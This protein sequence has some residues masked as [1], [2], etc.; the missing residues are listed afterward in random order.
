LSAIPQDRAQQAKV[1]ARAP[2]RAPVTARDLLTPLFFFKTRAIIA[3]IL[4][5]LAALAVAAT[6][7]HVYTADTRLLIL[8]GDDYT[9]RNPLSA[10]IPGLSFDRAQIVKAET[11]IIQS[12]GLIS[13]TVQAVGLNRLFPKAKGPGA[14]NAA[15]DKVAASITVENIPQ[16]NVVAITMKGR[17]PVVVSDTLNKLVELY[18]ARRRGIFDQNNTSSVDA[19]GKALQAQ[20]AQIEGQIMDFTAKN[21]VTDVPTELGVIAAQMNGLRQQIA[22]VD[23]QLADRNGRSA[24]LRSAQASNPPKMEV[25]TDYSRSLEMDGLEQSLVSLQNQRRDAAQEYVDNSPVVRDLDERIAGVKAQLARAPKQQVNATRQGVN[26]VRQ[27]IDQ[28]IMA[29]QADAA[30]LMAARSVAMEQL[31]QV[32][33]LETRLLSLA[34]DYR[35]LTRKRDLLEAAITDLAKRG[36]E[37]RLAN[38]VSRSQANIRVLQTAHPPTTSHTGRPVILAAGVV[39]GIVAA[40]GVVLVS[41]ALFQGMLTPSAAMQKLATPVAATINNEP[42]LKPEANTM[43]TPEPMFMHS[44][45]AR[46]LSHVVHSLSR[47]RCVVQVMGTDDNVGV[48]ALIADFA[49]LAARDRQKVLLLDLEPSPGRSALDALAARGAL[50]E[51]LHDN[52]S[53]VRVTGT[54]LFVT[55]NGARGDSTMTEREWATLLDAIAKDFD[56]LLIDAPP[57]SRSLLSLFAAPSVDATLLVIEAEK[58]RAPVALNTIERIGGV[59]GEVLATLFNKRRFYIPRAVYERL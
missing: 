55:R 48:T 20:L 50:F 7:P 2:L 11:E 41:V 45:A 47:E 52:G 36:E 29:S 1:Q 9:F 42:D 14:L 26:P 24:V 38:S 46:M 4:P 31:D 23:R 8:P 58:T 57:L 56:L 5:L 17:D 49:L 30:G 54:S 40:T 32:S 27:D 28:R 33:K 35:I 34:P 43:G 21:Q 39:V 25:T 19:E 53:I 22:D 3:F 18:L 12:R 6:A 13:D 44:G 37:S 15:V 16:S 10:A 59:G 51:P